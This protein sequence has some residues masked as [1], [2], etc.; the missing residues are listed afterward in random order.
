MVVIGQRNTRLLTGLPRLVQSLDRTLYLVRA[1]GRYIGAY[2]IGNS[3]FCRLIHQHL[4]IFCKISHRRKDNGFAIGIDH[5]LCI[6]RHMKRSAQHMMRGPGHAQTA[7]QRS[8][9]LWLHPIIPALHAK[10]GFDLLIPDGRYFLQGA[11]DI[12]ID[13]REKGEQL[14]AD[15]MGRPRKKVLEKGSGPR[16]YHQPAKCSSTR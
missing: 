5:R 4:H 12:L 15:R 7:H 13:G 6:R 11:R 10:G 1:L 14:Q 3:S 2:Q 9:F 16:G 8:K